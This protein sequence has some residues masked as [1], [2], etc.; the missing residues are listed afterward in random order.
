MKYYVTHFQIKTDDEALFRPSC[1]LLA[2]I[3]GECGYESFMD[4]D[5]G[6]DGYI[7][8]DAYDEQLL[9]ESLADFPVDGVALNFVTE[10]VE[11]QNWNETWEQEEGFEPISIAGKVLI[12]DLYHTDESELSQNNEE[13]KIGIEA[14]NAFGTGTHET[15]R[16]MV[17]RLIASDLRGKRI[18][19]CGCGTGILAVAA[20][21]CGAEEA[22]AYDIDEWS[23][24]NTRH[25]AQIN[26]AADR[27][28][29]LEGDVNVL[30]HVSGV[31]DV[32]MANINRNIL[33]SD[34][35]MFH[36]VMDKGA[37]LMLSGFYDTD[38]PI[39]VERAES[40]GLTLIDKIQEGDWC[41][42]EFYS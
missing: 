7:Q 17:S 4:T 22:V 24:E 2:A 39:L 41:S 14:R 28:H 37:H 32:V 23:V 10:E 16:L 21:K 6:V 30:S 15:T 12:Y 35:E 5:T 1:E 18:L 11:D 26:G 38:V 42:L 19:D 36:N 3:A 27:L 25:N 33:L 13:I 31:F 8:V 34:M 29:V 9:V 40:L 20:I